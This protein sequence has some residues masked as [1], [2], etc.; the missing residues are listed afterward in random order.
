MMVRLHLKRIGEVVDGDA[1]I[2]DARTPGAVTTSASSTT[3]GVVIDDVPT[4][5]VPQRGTTRRTDDGT[6]M[7][8]RKK[9]KK[10]CPWHAKDQCDPALQPC[11]PRRTDYVRVRT[12][13]VR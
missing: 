6:W 4:P 2:D 13:F 10:L 8:T 11:G 5:P 9:G 12:R 1:P 7:D 3:P